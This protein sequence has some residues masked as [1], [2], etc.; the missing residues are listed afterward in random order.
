MCV[1]VAITFI[2]RLRLFNSSF[3]TFIHSFVHALL[4]IV[5]RYT[6][7]SLPS[8]IY[9]S[10]DF[11]FQFYTD[12]FLLVSFLLRNF[13][14]T[15]V[16][17]LAN[18]YYC[19]YTTNVRKSWKLF[20][21][22]RLMHR[23]SRYRGPK[24]VS[25]CGTNLLR[26]SVRWTRSGRARE[27][28]IRKRAMLAGHSVDLTKHRARRRARNAGVTNGVAS[29]QQRIISFGG[30]REGERDC[31]PI[32]IPRWSGNHPLAASSTTREEDLLVGSSGPE[33]AQLWLISR[34]QEG[35]DLDQVFL[36][37]YFRS[38][39]TI[40]ERGRGRVMVGKIGIGR[41]LSALLS[42]ALSRSREAGLEGIVSPTH[43]ARNLRV[44]AAQRDW[45][46][47]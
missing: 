44:S 33:F 20:E 10:P 19:C 37:N 34:L 47:R 27:S 35:N 40:G 42:I 21:L 11:F 26:F 29:L 46:G 43:R 31:C 4:F 16:H 3:R 15:I 12:R 45:R 30:T 25:R 2:T 9:N 36:V 39:Y 24:Q 41:L 32:E 17:K 22:P 8:G 5:T 23:D 13:S 7:R 38:V 18:C 28:R 14:S 1:Y 6:I